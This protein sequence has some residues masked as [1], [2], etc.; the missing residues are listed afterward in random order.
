VK[1]AG[2][3][4]CLVGLVGGWWP[5]G[6]PRRWPKPLVLSCRGPCQ[7]HPAG[8]RRGAGPLLV[9]RWR[10]ERSARRK[11]GSGPGPGS[12]PGAPRVAATMR[13]IPRPQPLPRAFPASPGS[14]PEQAQ[15]SRRG[16]RGRQP[17]VAE[18]DPPVCPAQ[19]ARL[20]GLGPAR[21]GSPARAR[22][23]GLP[24]E[25]S[26]PPKRGPPG[27]P[28][29]DPETNRAEAQSRLPP[30]RGR[31]WTVPTPGRPSQPLE[32]DRPLRFRPRS[33]VV[34]LGSRPGPTARPRGWGSGSWAAASPAGSPTPPPGSPAKGPWR[35]PRGDIARPFA[36]PRQRPRQ[37][38]PRRRPRP[39]QARPLATARARSSPCRSPPRHPPLGPCRWRRLGS[40][41]RRPH[42][43]RRP[44]HLPREGPD[45]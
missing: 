13:A 11:S 34:P 2:A 42:P 38:A 31:E 12:G 16:G 22:R 19:T 4:Q 9:R 27:F 5:G 24:A 26:P 25:P 44:R 40:W 35:R 45:G 3:W 23:R 29:Q 32:T 41:H 33:R 43:R 14:V 6:V 7:T 28:G 1:L 37:Q 18:E 15:A 8:I 39:W 20:P 30:C 21:G 10:R 36:P 17:E